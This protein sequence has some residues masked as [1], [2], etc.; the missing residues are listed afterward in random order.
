MAPRSS[1]WPVLAADTENSAASSH[2]ISLTQRAV[3][4]QHDAKAIIEHVREGRGS[5]PKPVMQ[6][7]EAALKT[8]EM[9]TTVNLDSD[10]RREL[11]ELSDRS[12]REFAQLRHD[13]TTVR[14]QTD[15]K[16]TLR[17]VS[18]GGCGT[19]WPVLGIQP[20]NHLEHATQIIAEA[21]ALLELDSTK[22][23]KL[24]GTS[25]EA[26]L[27]SVINLA[28][29]AR[30]QPSGQEILGKLNSLQPIVE[31]IILIKNAVNNA[32]A[33]PAPVAP[34]A[35]TRI[36]SWADVVRSGA[37]SYPSTPNS[38]ASTN[39]KCQG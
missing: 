22:R 25:V 28:K 11:K 8:A 15:P 6:F 33:S 9:L 13:V 36:A 19:I 24:P 1:P 34:N 32:L 29:K 4:Q 30:E 26:F 17:S 20:L 21:T 37:P 27:N 2:T 7:V 23:A 35:A 39:R 31:D 3:N 5:L 38:R 14:I 18:S 10:L 16:N 12:Q